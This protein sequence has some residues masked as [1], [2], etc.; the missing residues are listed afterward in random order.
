M[1]WLKLRLHT[2]DRLRDWRKRGTGWENHWTK[3]KINSKPTK[4]TSYSLTDQS[5]TGWKRW[6]KSITGWKRW[7]LLTMISRTAFRV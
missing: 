2:K 4:E 5:I 6:N 7:K 3:L 1:S